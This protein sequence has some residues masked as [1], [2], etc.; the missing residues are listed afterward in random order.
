[1]ALTFVTEPSREDWNARIAATPNQGNVFQSYELGQ[2]K[3][4][5]RW[6]PRYAEVD[7]LAMTIHEKSGAPFGTVW[8]LPKGPCVTSPE[9]LAP[10]VEGLREAGRRE[11]VLFVRMEPEYV[12]T[13]EAVRA[14]QALGLVRTEPVQPHSS[15][16]LIDIS[17]TEEELLASFTAKT[18]NKVRRAIKDGVQIERAPDTEQT[19]E[20]MWELWQDVVR[21]QELGVRSKDY[22]VRSWRT[23][24]AGGNA[25]VFIA[26][27]EG[28]P[29]ASALVMAISPVACYKEGASLRDR[30]VTGGSQ[31]MQWEA[32]RWAQERGCTVY[33]MCGTPHS[34]RMDDESHPR[35]GIGHFKA[36]FTK[37]KAPVTDWVGAWDLVL[38]PRRYA[39]WN[40]LGERLVARAQRREPGDVFW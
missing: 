37:D 6:R 29:V 25:Q 27:A 30:P 15:T 1:M 39:L 26:R 24:V 16:I 14:T 3:E 36:G 19:Y 17:G 18:R 22:H 7:G 23:L 11:G 33:D 34:T 4:Q 13:P 21:D 5:A 31:L 40:R 9:Q 32:M 38:R 10:V 12:G 8:Y 28:V 35:H 2:V 20:E